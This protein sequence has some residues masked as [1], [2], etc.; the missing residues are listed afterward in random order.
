MID[1]PV[2]TCFNQGNNLGMD[3]LPDFDFLVK[4]NQALFET[5]FLHIDALTINFTDIDDFNV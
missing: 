5:Y 1:V 2:L 3:N 4:D